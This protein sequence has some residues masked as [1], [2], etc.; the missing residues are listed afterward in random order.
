[1]GPRPRAARDGAR[2]VHWLRTLSPNLLGEMKKEYP[3]SATYMEG[4]AEANVIGMGR[5]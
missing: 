4:I 3:R 2:G 1:M 5:R